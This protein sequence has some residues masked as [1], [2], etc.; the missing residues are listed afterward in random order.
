MEA[1]KFPREGA[2]LLTS[3]TESD[4]LA[5][6]ADQRASVSIGDMIRFYRHELLW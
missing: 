6:L 3:L 2:A 5:E 4:G 1:H